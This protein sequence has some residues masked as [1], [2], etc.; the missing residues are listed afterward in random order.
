[1]T[2]HTILMLLANPVDTG[3]IR[4]DKEFD[5]IQ[6]KLYESN[7]RDRFELKPVLATT[8]DSILEN[9]QRHRPS[10]IHFSGH[11]EKNSSEISNKQR[12]FSRDLKSQTNENNQETASMVL[13][14][15]DEE[16]FLLKPSEF[17]SLIQPKI[18]KD[19]LQLVVFNACYMDAFVEQVHK[20]VPCVIGTNDAVPDD[21]AIEFSKYFY[22][23]LANGCTIEEAYT[24][25]LKR[26]DI[27]SIVGTGIH[28]LKGKGEI[29][30]TK[31]ETVVKD[32][33]PKKE[34][35][36]AVIQNATGESS[37]AIYLEK[38]DGT[39]TIG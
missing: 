12:H 32:T 9:V 11:G 31:G 26:A 16:T 1:M 8:V 2:K 36:K 5:E 19:N 13:E 7:H 29:V 35:G 17:V 4:L 6:K 34:E 10:I 24:V 20:E 15:N 18:V 22:F 28:C 25:S 14:G 21:R 3:R 23:S 33:P 30:F 37:K 38:N 27:L 39:I